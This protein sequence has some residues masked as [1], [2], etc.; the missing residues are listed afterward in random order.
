M[1]VLEGVTMVTQ[2]DVIWCYRNLLRRPPES[3]EIVDFWVRS[4]ADWRDLV[5]R[6][7]ASVEYKNHW[8]DAM[9]TGL[10]AASRLWAVEYPG[11]TVVSFAQ[12]CEDVLLYRAFK[13]KAGGTFI[14]V[15][16]GHPIADNVT[17]WLR[18]KG[19]RGV[20]VEPNPIFFRDLQKYRPEDINLN[21]GVADKAG[22]LLFYQ[23]EQNEVGHGWGL[24]SFDAASET[25]AQSMGFKVNRMKIP[26]ITLN[27]IAEKH[28]PGGVDVLKLDVE[29][30]EEMIIR[31]TDW[32]HFRPKL[33]CIEAIEPVSA[34]PAWPKWENY[35][36]NA[37]YV[38]AAFDGCNCYYCPVEEE[39]V[40]GQLSAPICWNDNYRRATNEDIAA[41]ARPYE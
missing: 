2:D 41:A 6:F 40:R 27:E 8:R 17:L 14:D 37:D 4:A 20:N 16:A 31:S 36:L 13:G 26:V 15:G 33:L 29:G 38:F 12:N 3:Q 21:I 19:W 28:Y 35:L 32:R 39:S 7:L 5:G 23:V 10:P 24:S 34:R 30:L 22:E 11:E 18:Q 1:P 25:L 9:T